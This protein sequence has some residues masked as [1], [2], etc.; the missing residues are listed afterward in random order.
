[1]QHWQEGASHANHTPEVDLEEPFEIF[2]GNLLERAAHRDACIVDKQVNAT[3]FGRHDIRKVSHC[4]AVGYIDAMSRHMNLM[5]SDEIRC[6]GH[7]G[8]IYIG[9]REVATATR[10]RNSDR[11]SDAAAGTGDHSCTPFEPHSL[12]H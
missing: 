9:E 3:V 2:V 1:L 11:S 5:W 4:G 7:S 10:K 8:F 12:S 6:V